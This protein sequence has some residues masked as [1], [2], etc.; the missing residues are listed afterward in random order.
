MKF[1][2]QSLKKALQALILLA[3]LLNISSLRLSAQTIPEPSRQE[4]LNG[5]RV[6]IWN[7]P[8][9]GNVYLKL[10]IHSGAAFDLA[11]K[12]G[13]MALLSDAL[14][15]DPTTREYFV[16]ELGGR[17]DVTSDYDGITVMLSGNASKFE[18]IIELLSTALISTELTP[19]VIEK[20]REARIKM[21]RDLEISPTLTADRAI[22]AR[23][24][25]DYPYGRPRA[26]SQESLARVDRADL[27]KARERFLNPN[28]ATL[29]I[30]G[31][32]DERR[33]MRALKQL[34]GNWRKSDTMVPATFRQ[35]EVP[36]SRTL[37]VDLPGTEAAEVRVAAR[38]LARSDKDAAAA[39]LL[40]LAARDLWQTQQP[41]L[42]KTGFY[43]RH[44]PHQ[45]PGMFVMG[46][47]VPVTEAANTLAKARNVLNMLM[48]TGVPADILERVRSEAIAELTKQIERP[49]TL[50]DLW[51]DS[52]TFQTGSFDEQLRQLKAVSGADLIRTANKLFKD[53]PIVSVAAGSASR[54]KTA[55]GGTGKI[56]VLGEVTVPAPTHTPVPEK[57]Q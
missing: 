21:V 6:L 20:L 22:A 31:N 33:A 23:L 10:R 29:V 2:I 15:P 19:P 26:G 51:L 9:D 48:K 12:A 18:R 11:G 32:V 14:F 47:S 53:A 45:L 56:E 43:V 17:V 4:L 46:A 7:R 30:I 52:H 37:I 1:Q 8:A 54:L 3:F 50:A 35:P 13:T 49:E 28:N 16:E 41:E 42:G 25:A 27:M 57:K 36:D 34:L 40:A 39:T 55:L 5:L 44:E 24:F 38:G